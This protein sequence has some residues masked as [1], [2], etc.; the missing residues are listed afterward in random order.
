MPS[1]SGPRTR[2]P[3]TKKVPCPYTLR[4]PLTIDNDKEIVAVVVQG[5]SC[6]LFRFHAETVSIGSLTCQIASIKSASKRQA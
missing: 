6:R 1:L 2:H 4:D 3:G 5:Y